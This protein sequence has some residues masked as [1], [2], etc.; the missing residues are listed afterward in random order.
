MTG[1]G[2]IVPKPFAFRT[3]RWHHAI[4]RVSVVVGPLLATH[5]QYLSSFFA[6]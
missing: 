6:V 1:I 4:I 5:P 3:V 2:G